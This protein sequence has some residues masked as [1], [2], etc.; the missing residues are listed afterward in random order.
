MIYDKMG[1]SRPT[2]PGWYRCVLVLVR[3]YVVIIV[4]IRP[5]IDP[6]GVKRQIGRERE[7]TSIERTKVT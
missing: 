2:L 1:S 5:S 4:S 7:I 3:I 6:H